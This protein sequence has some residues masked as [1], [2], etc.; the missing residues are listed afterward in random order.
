MG[1]SL[2]ARVLVRLLLFAAVVASVLV[3]VGRTNADPSFGLLDGSPSLGGSNGPGD[4]FEPSATGP[5]SVFQETAL[6]L[7][8]DTPID[9]I[10]FGNDDP[11]AGTSVVLFSVDEISLGYPRAIDDVYSEAAGIDAAAAA[12]TF[13]SSPRPAYAL[14]STCGAAPNHVVL[15][16]DGLLAGGPERA[17]LP[18]AGLDEGPHGPPG[19]EGRD[20]IAFF[21]ASDNLAVD[22]GGDGTPDQPVYFSVPSGTDPGLPNASGA[23]VFVKH[24]TQGLQL[25][26]SATS[27]GLDSSDDIDALAVYQN[28]VVF[29]LARDSTSVGTTALPVGTCGLSAASSTEADLF[30]KTLGGALELYLSAEQLGLCAPRSSGLCNPYS[31]TGNDNVDAIDIVRLSGQDDDGDGRDNAVDYDDD[32]DGT[33]DWQDDSDADGVVDSVDNCRS[34]ANA[35]QTNSDSGPPPP[36]W[37]TG[38]WGNGPDVP[39]EDWTVASGDL[40]GDACDA[41]DDND[42]LPDVQ[43]GPILS[44]CNPAFDGTPANHP[45]PAGGDTTITDANGPSW[46]T[47]GDHVQDGVECVAG[48]NPRSGSSADR[49]A[50]SNYVG[51][52][53]ESDA[54]GDGLKDG[55]EVCAW[56]TDRFGSNADGDGLGDCREAMDVTG[57]GAITGGDYTFITQAA[58]GLIAAD[59]IFDIN[60]NGT[61]TNGDATFVKQVFFGIEPCL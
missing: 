43:D 61:V 21:D 6:G 55:W 20:D 12:D 7:P 46:D 3:V 17:G 36:A 16:G 29:S 38:G 27:L 2:R 44:A 33:P 8:T 13:A 35:P 10:S 34:A 14:P 53:I 23:D 47:D 24:P 58:F 49:T 4:T 5:V 15:D 52:P 60:G 11:R 51:A 40:T 22:A 19:T 18:A 32:N 48:T 28:T 41:D 37:H 50:C 56:R 57:N 54:D 31:D 25:F 26:A 42:G 59:W 1:R 9:A 39:D 30:V 45:N